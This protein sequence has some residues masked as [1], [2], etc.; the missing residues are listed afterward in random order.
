MNRKIIG[1]LLA[2]LVFAGAASAHG[3]GDGHSGK[4]FSD[5][6]G[7]ELT[8]EQKTQRD[9]MKKIHDELRAEL[10][11]SNPDKARARKLFE[12]QLSMKNEFMTARFN[13]C[14]A[15]GKNGS[16]DGR[17][18]KG[19]GGKH[20]KDGRDSKVWSDFNAEMNKANPDKAKAS[21]L[22]KSA[23]AQNK[24]N[25]MARFEEV[26]KDPSKYLNRKDGRKDDGRGKNFRG[27]QQPCTQGAACPNGTQCP[28]GP[29]CP[30][31]K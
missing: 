5:R 31:A 2:V 20:H 16:A 28:G 13:D 8:Q 23:L 12:K 24:K 1:A 14:F 29:R 6:G 10:S 27:S 30:A 4:G 19:F 9:A 11:K 26:L 21:A 22:F 3:Y 7:R 17:G 18:F 25:E 15:Q